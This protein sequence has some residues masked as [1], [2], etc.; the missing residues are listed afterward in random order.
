MSSRTQNI[1]ITK[2]CTLVHVDVA[3]YSKISH[4]HKHLNADH[5]M[6]SSKKFTYSIVYMQT[7]RN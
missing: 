1:V 5:V 3:M 6:L 4:L 7:S 2:V